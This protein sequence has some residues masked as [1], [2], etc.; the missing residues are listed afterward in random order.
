MR[1]SWK[2]ILRY[3][4]RPNLEG[5]STK[6]YQRTPPEVAGQK[7][8]QSDRQQHWG[9]KATVIRAVTPAFCSDSGSDINLIPPDLVKG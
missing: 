4:L 2:A 6:A 7:D 3:R 5:E 1:C 8:Q 9:P